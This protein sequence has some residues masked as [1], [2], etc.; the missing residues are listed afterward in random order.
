[1]LAPED[2]RAQ[3]D[4]YGGI[5]YAASPVNYR[6]IPSILSCNRIHGTHICLACSPAI[7]CVAVPHHSTLSDSVH[8]PQD[9][10]RQGV[11]RRWFSPAGGFGAKTS[12]AVA[13]ARGLGYCVRRMTAFQGMLPSLRGLGCG[14]YVTS[15]IVSGRRWNRFAANSVDSA[16]R[17]VQPR[18]SK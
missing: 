14:T 5:E 7:S 10:V 15:R 8:T 18:F 1:M 16:S 13:W 3:C 2:G 6:I 17:V 4:E 11:G 9:G 12:G